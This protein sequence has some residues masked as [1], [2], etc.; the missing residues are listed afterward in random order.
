MAAQ[1]CITIIGTGLVGASLGM[2]ILSSRGSEIEV[3]GHDRDHGQANLARRMGAV[4]KVDRNL[5]SAASK[6]DM[7]ILA[8]PALEIRET[9]EL[10][11]ND[12]KAGCVVHDTAS[13]KAPV[14]QWADELLP[15]EVSYVGGDPILFG[16][17]AGIESARADL[18]AQKQYCITPSSR[19]SSEAVRLV[20]DLVAMTGAIPHYIDPYE[21]DGLIGGT[22]HLADMVAI[23]F[24]HV[25][26]AA[27][28]G[29][30]LPR[31]GGA[32]FGRVAALSMPHADP[33]E[34]RGRALYNRDNLL[35]WM[36][37]M[38]AELSQFHALI[39]RGDSGAIEDYYAIEMENRLMWLRDRASQSWGDMPEQAD[40]PTS[41]EFLSEMLFGGL[42]RRRREE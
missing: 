34:Y 25:L 35:R 27:Q 37:G 3:L 5:I 6:A 17:E 16:D 2:A 28:D 1:P 32:T 40:I 15:P 36:D 12:L 22:D 10:I 24:L 14:L 29:Q 19:A 23:A 42:A 39:E 30:E 11:A 21:H 8:I 18:F 33:S 41:G 4:S 38:Q 31:R 13:V 7:L 9:L 26:H 20:T